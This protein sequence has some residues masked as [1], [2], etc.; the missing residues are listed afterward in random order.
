MF[1]LESL[2]IAGETYANS[3]SVKRACDFLIGKQKE[4]GGWGET[5]LVRRSGTL[6]LSPVVG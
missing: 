4:D 5:Y 1:A 3:D 6:A 2:H